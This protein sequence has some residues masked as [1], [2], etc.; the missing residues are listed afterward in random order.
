MS[1]SSVQRLA[2]L[3][4]GDNVSASRAGEIVDLAGQLGRATSYHVFGAPPPHCKT[5]WARALEEQ[6]VAEMRVI[7]NVQGKNGADIRM[8][9]AGVE[10]YYQGAAD[11]YL[12]VTHD[13]DLIP[14]VER[15]KQTGRPIY[16]CATSQ[17]AHQLQAACDSFFRLK[18]VPPP[19]VTLQ[20][21]EGPLQLQTAV[22]EAILVCATIDGW[23][24]LS[25]LGTQLN[26][27]A[28]YGKRK[29]G[30]ANLSKLLKAAGFQID[31][32]QPK[33]RAC[34][35]PSMLASYQAV[36]EAE[37]T[38]IEAMEGA[39]PQ[40]PQTPAETSAETRTEKP[41]ETDQ[42]DQASTDE[43]QTSVTSSPETSSR[44]LFL[45][46][47]VTEIQGQTLAE[48]REFMRS[49]LAEP[50]APDKSSDLLSA[51]TSPHST[52]PATT[53]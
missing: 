1:S 9:L 12:I 49:Q 18:S 48:A 47:E 43:S 6:L 36:V 5:W 10:L 45:D 24:D 34:V 51:S 21:I 14:L 53:R 17:V 16:G 46:Y 37:T 7:R 8:A 28:Q 33:H 35:P 39:H 50:P 20:E 29:F 42:T 23:A 2:V 30:Y 4:D 25:A 44:Q 31:K 3:I 32:S 22:I 11:G 19:T 40:I 15:L 27:H 41:L 13:G 26:G 52:K 38:P